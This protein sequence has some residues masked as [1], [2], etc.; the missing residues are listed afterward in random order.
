MLDRM[1]YN[2][3]LIY[4]QG[5]YSLGGDANLSYKS[6]LEICFM[7]SVKPSIVSMFTPF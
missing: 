4:Q 2:G 7:P 6:Y 1:E 5:M 3:D